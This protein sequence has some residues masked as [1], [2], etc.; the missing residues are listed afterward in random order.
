MLNEGRIARVW[1]LDGLTLNTADFLTMHAEVLGVPRDEGG[2]PADE[3][4]TLGLIDM[5]GA[6]WLDAAAWRDYA[7][8]VRRLGPVQV[9]GVVNLAYES[10]HL[11]AQVHAL[12]ELNPTDLIVTHLDEESRWGKVWNLVLGTNC[13]IRFFCAGQNVPGTFRRADPQ[14]I[15][16]R[17]FP[18]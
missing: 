10:A 4:G 13:R 12:S 18:A 2:T 5:P 6:D 11:A 7:V 1:R 14:M 9:H 8:V 15:L 17:Q 3:P 16:A